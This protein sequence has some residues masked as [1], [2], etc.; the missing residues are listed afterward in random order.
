MITSLRKFA[1]HQ[2]Q[3]TLVD[4]FGRGHNYLRISLTEKCNFRCQYCMPPDGIELTEEAKILTRG[5][6]KRLVSLFVDRF[7]VDKI[8]LTGGEPTVRKDLV[9]IISDIRTCNPSIQSIGITT[10]GA[11]LPRKLD[12]LAAAGLDSINIS[13]DSLVAA[14]NEMITR[15]VNTT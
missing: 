7:E 6:V 1:T 3:R 10:N 13:L 2:G 15:R 8:R 12:A 14:K 5:D 4:K 11:L 9:D